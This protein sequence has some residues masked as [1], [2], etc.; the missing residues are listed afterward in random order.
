M[1]HPKNEEDEF[2]RELRDLDEASDD[3]IAPLANALPTASTDGGVRSRL[4]A[5]TE[6]THRFEELVDVI[7]NDADLPASRVDELLLAI[8]QPETWESGPAPG[9]DLFHFDGGPKTARAITGFVRIETGGT[10]PEHGHLGAEVVVI[11]QGEARDTRTG[12]VHGRGDRVTA[13]PG[14]EHALVVTSDIPFVYLAVVE[15]GIRI[16]ERELKYDDPDI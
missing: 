6:T 12:K 5:S 7:A 3:A 10:F 9:I 1:T 13:T 15:E 4:L 11:L 8:D 2:L 14:D 16:G